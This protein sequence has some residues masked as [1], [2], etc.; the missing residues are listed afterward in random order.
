MNERTG[1]TTNFIPTNE[2]R[3]PGVENS[4]CEKG[5][6]KGAEKPWPRIKKGGRRFGQLEL[7]ES[8]GTGGGG[9]RENRKK[10]GN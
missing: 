5:K 7:L 4:Q 2:E 1:T 8:T 3:K 6:K 9:V 10:K